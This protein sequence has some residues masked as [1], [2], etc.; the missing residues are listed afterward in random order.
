MLSWSPSSPSRLSSR[1]HMSGR[2][3]RA[4]G[5]QWAFVTKNEG[6]RDA[7]FGFWESL[8]GIRHQQLSMLLFLP[9]CW[10]F[11]PRTVA[12]SRS[13]PPHTCEMP[14]PRTWPRVGSGEERETDGRGAAI[15]DYDSV[16]GRR[17]HHAPGKGGGVRGL[18]A[19]IWGQGRQGESEIQRGA[20][21]SGETQTRLWV[22]GL[23]V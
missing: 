9:R 23:G 12:A 7:G 8:V 14:T 5:F 19:E 16:C 22:W 20:Q 15:N 1:S 11:G 3:F 4:N 21:G 6:W 10:P 17:R 18:G 2:R 13:P